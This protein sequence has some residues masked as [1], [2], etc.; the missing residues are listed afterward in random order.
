MELLKTDAF[1]NNTWRPSGLNERF[2][3]YNPSNGKVIAQ[4]ANC[5][6]EDT[7]V[8]I[9]AALGAWEAWR[10]ES[11]TV[12][13]QLLQTWGQLID[14]HSDALT[15]L[16]Q[17]EAGKSLGDAR[18][19]VAYANSFVEWYAQE[20]LRIHGRTLAHGLTGAQVAS[21]TIQEPIGVVAAITP[22]NFP[23]AMVTRKAAAALAAGCTLIL[24][25]AEDTPLI[26]LA[27]GQ[28]AL[29]AG[30]PAGVLNIVPTQ[31][32]AAIGELLSTHPDIAKLS[33]T[34]STQ[35]GKILGSQAAATTKRLSLELGGNAPFIVDQ[36]AQI[37]DAIQGALVA[38]FRNNGQSCVAANRFFV[39]STH[40][41]TFVARLVKAAKA[42]IVGATDRPN[43]ELGPLIHPQAVT[44]IHTLI[45]DALSKGAHLLVDG[46]QHVLGPC[47][48]KPT[49]L[50]AVTDTMRITQEEIFGPVVAVQSFDLLE[51]ALV[52]AN[53]TTYGLAA[54]VYAQ[55]SKAI[56]QATQTLGAGMIG[57]NTGR[58][59]HA[60]TPFGG[61]KASGWGK[62]GGHWGLEEF[63]ETKYVAWQ[64]S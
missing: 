64:T 45:E 1:I 10:K 26:A 33:F 44:R 38:K 24:K 53:A 3:V 12:R 13:S 46:R 63:M 34:G 48:L 35:V 59:S 16:L 25:P 23:L 32:P 52:R 49:V 9:T 15:N 22:W 62:E 2:E 51:E 56:W 40:Y 58:V 42:Y 27:L 36:S 5:T 43:T 14:K 55:D 28:L 11:P 29:A 37:E 20:A 54:Y 7:Q 17:V 21:F 61:I 30:L 41:D 57:I 18:S 39:H 8:A 31:S 50:G 47:F 6:P 19:E 4:V 60:S